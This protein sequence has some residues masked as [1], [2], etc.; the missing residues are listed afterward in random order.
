MFPAFTPTST[1]ALG[2]LNDPLVEGQG[3][4]SPG[5]CLTRDNI[6]NPALAEYFLLQSLEPTDDE[7]AGIT[8]ARD[9]ALNRLRLLV[10]SDPA[11]LPAKTRPRAEG[12]ILI[13]NDTCHRYIHKFVSDELIPALSSDDQETVITKIVDICDIIFLGTKAFTANGGSI[14]ARDSGNNTPDITTP[15]VPGATAASPIPNRA[16]IRRRQAQT[17][18]K[19]RERDQ[20]C[21]IFGRKNK[22]EVAHIIP[23]SLGSSP[24]T[25]SISNQS[26]P[27]PVEV[28]RP[29]KQPSPSFWKL[30]AMF[31]GP[32]IVESLKT[33]FRTLDTLENVI[34]L[35]KDAHAFFGEG[36]LS[37]K[38][39]LSTAE[40]AS[41]DPA[42]TSQASFKPHV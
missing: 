37:F 31:G 9:F 41:Y 25:P 34:L 17:A 6:P 18:A 11:L 5:V 40:A 12:L 24:A 20:V 42:V 16:V 15:S 8:Q 1:G 38:P 13:L 23:F 21:P 29:C 30:L 4:E 27:L 33:R 7:M 19:C 36:T 32:E 2:P 3:Q 39:I 35:G 14:S 28:N 26:S 10:D 22:E